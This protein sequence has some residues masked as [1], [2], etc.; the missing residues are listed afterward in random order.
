MDSRCDPGIDGLSMRG[1]FY[2]DFSLTP[3]YTTGDYRIQRIGSMTST[4]PFIFGSA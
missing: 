3:T 2:F 1:V 4:Y